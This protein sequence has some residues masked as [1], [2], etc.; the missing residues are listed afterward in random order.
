MEALEEKAKDREKEKSPKIKRTR[1]RKNKY[2]ESDSEKSMMETEL[3]K[4][5]GKSDSGKRI[6]TRDKLGQPYFTPTSNN[7]AQIIKDA[8][9]HKQEEMNISPGGK[10]VPSRL[11]GK[12]EIKI[13]ADLDEGWRMEEVVAE[14]LRI[15]SQRRRKTPNVHIEYAEDY[16]MG[17]T[18]LNNDDNVIREGEDKGTAEGKAEKGPSQQQHVDDREGITWA[19]VVKKSNRRRP[20]VRSQREENGKDNR[21]RN[22]VPI[23]PDNRKKAKNPSATLARAREN[24]RKKIPKSSAVVLTCSDGQY[25]DTVKMVRGG[26]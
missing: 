12:G 8:S 11:I 22:R 24:N 21:F 14:A 19:T 20:S 15:I 16:A 9:E 7:P 6:E 4:E 5:R 10:E 26:N 3:L 25:H 17:S 13:S 23:R 2:V 18:V 1:E